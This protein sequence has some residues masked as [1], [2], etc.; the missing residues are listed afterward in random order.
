MK[1]HGESQKLVG[2]DGKSTG[3]GRGHRVTKPKFDVDIGCYH[4]D[5]SRIDFKLIV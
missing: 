4:D 1:P 5:S 2:R 3:C